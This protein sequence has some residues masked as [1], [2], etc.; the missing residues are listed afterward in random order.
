MH[1]AAGLRLLYVAMTPTTQHLSVVATAPL[2]PL[3]LG[4]PA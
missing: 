2:H 1:R 3:L 4:E